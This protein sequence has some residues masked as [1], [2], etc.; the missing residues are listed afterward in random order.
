MARQK[1]SPKTGGRVAGVPNKATVRAKEA[2]AAFVDGNADRL[3]GWLDEI[4]EKDGP[5][6]AFGCVT[7]L[8][9]YHL[10][11]LARNDGTQ[12]HEGDVK[13]TVTWGE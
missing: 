5:K 13:F 1:G 9:E 11:K 8:L 2:I 6:E 12:K 3:N 7:S 4:Y 10:P